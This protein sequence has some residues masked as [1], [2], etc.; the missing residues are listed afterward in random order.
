MNYPDFNPASPNTPLSDAELQQLDELLASLPS[1]AAMNI[2][3]MDGYLTG[4]WLLPGV[5][6][7]LGTADWLP[8][9]WGGDGAEAAPFP[10]QRQRKNTT[11]LVLRHLQ[12]LACQWRDDVESWEPIFSVA[13]Q[14]EREWV[15][16]RDWCTG[17]LQ[18]T[19]LAAQDWDPL[20]DDPQ[21]GP[22][23]VPIALL[24]GEGQD[25]DAA[26]DLDDPEVLDSLSRSVPDAVLALLVRRNGH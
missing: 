19:D 6:E 24:G 17:F 15:D 16:A 7:R 23:L 3:G 25:D 8:L 1:E 4:L 21:I 11:V 22:L 5:L 26:A 14:G 13:E 18:A 2:E 12:S 10:S 20:W 9:V